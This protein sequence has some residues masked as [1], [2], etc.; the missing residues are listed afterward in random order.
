MADGR[1][2]KAEVLRPLPLFPL[3]SIPLFPP[4][5]SSSVG[6]PSCLPVWLRRSGVSP[7]LNEMKLPWTRADGALSRVC[8]QPCRPWSPSTPRLPEVGGLR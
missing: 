2:A 4:P 5:P 6:T 8:L 7:P 1:T 3:F